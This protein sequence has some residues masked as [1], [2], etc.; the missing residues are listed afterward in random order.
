MRPPVCEQHLQTAA[1]E[2]VPCSNSP[3]INE[4]I[5]TVVW[6]GSSI[7]KRVGAHDNTGPMVQTWFCACCAHVANMPCKAKS[8]LWVIPAEAMSES[9]ASPGPCHSFAKATFAHVTG[10]PQAPGTQQRNQDPA[11]G[12]SRGNLQFSRPAHPTAVFPSVSTSHDPC[13]EPLPRSASRI[14]ATASLPQHSLGPLKAQSA[15]RHVE[16]SADSSKFRMLNSNS[17]D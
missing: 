5:G 15:S 17:D 11:A 7:M 10:D 4:C 9:W 1:D 12:H 6:H 8:G 13:A 2:C 14:L 16:A 3:L